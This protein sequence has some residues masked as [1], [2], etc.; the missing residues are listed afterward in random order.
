MNN[1]KLIIFDCDG[2]LVD[3]ETL[4]NRACAGVLNY[5]GYKQYTPEYCL[6]KFV[7]VSLKDILDILRE[8]VGDEF[9]QSE[10]V[11]RAG[12]ISKKLI[13]TE[14]KPMS[15]AGDLLIKLK[16]FSK[17]VASNGNRS[18]VVQSLKSTGLYN[19]FTEESIFTYEL[20][21]HPKPAADLFL[22]SAE[23]MGVSPKEC[24]VIEDSIV[25]VR[26]AKAAKMDVLAY[27]HLNEKLLPGLNELKPTA[28]I[29]NLTQILD[30]L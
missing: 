9:D 26:A 28:I 15:N 20:V 30:Y 29:H 10:F 1:Y 2:T 8:E 6:E 22:Y 24:L 3:T 4:L 13:E 16:D 25:G 27:K 5:M 18:T 7:G 23:R 19:H 17:C 21:K 11:A 12:E 14:I